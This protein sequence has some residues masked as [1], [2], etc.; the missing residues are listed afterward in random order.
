MSAIEESSVEVATGIRRLLDELKSAEVQFC[1][2]KNNRQLGEALQGS[3]DLDLLVARAD[4]SRFDRVLLETGFRRADLPWWYQNE[5]IEHFFGLDEGTG[6]LL[7]I[8]VYYQIV[9]GGFV[10]KTHRLPIELH[11]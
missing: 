9:T 8:H 3:D 7:H 1:H 6:K 11:A 4:A 10:Y 2:W 5:A